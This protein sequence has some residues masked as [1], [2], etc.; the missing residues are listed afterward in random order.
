MSAFVLAMDTATEEVAL[1]LGERTG[2]R[3]ELVAD[4]DFEAP[5]AA[6]G[7]LLPAAQELLVRAGLTPSDIAEVVVGRGPGSFTGVRIGVSSAKGFAHG[8]GAPLFGVG[9]LDAIAWRFAETDGL[10][11]VVGDAMRG[12]VYPAL[13]RVASGQVR[14]LSDDTVMSPVAAAQM[15]AESVDEPLVLVGNGLRKYEDVFCATLGS[16]AVVAGRP[17]WTPAGV[18]LLAAYADARL[19]GVLGDGQ[20][21]AVLPVYTR[22]SDAE[23]NE[24]RALGNAPEMTPDSGVAGPRGVNGL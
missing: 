18:G 21:G 12:E 6:L 3:V 20:P 22:L 2:D 9:T 19:R 4:R 17:M 23:E 1:A 7:R 8:L 11:G 16:R 15:W 10:L 14:R 13:F 5:R 24:L